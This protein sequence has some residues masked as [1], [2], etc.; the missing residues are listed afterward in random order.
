MVLL[1]AQACGVPVVTSALGVMEGIADGMTGFTFPEKDVRA[2]VKRVREILGNSELASRMSAA[3]PVYLRQH[4]DIRRCTKKIE[5]LYD[6]IS[7]APTTADGMRQ[8]A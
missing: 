4:F 6:D 7:S 2:L 3:G 1:E 5:D 8:L